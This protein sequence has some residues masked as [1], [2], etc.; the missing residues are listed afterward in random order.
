MFS[1]GY[2][3]VALLDTQYENKTNELRIVKSRI[4]ERPRVPPLEGG[5]NQLRT[6]SNDG[7][8]PTSSEISNLLTFINEL[9]Q[10]SEIDSA[11]DDLSFN[12]T[13]SNSF[14]HV[15][16]QSRQFIITLFISLK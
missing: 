12:H 5:L 3:L 6:Q 7:K 10:F 13:N 2:S 8:L 16:Q 11:K 1:G 14:S 15:N 9:F 4:T